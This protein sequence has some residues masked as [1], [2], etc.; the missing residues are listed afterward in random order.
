MELAGN[1][2]ARRTELGMTLDALAE[3]SRVSRAML[4]DIEREAKSPTL[5]IVAQIASGLG[6]TVSQLLGEPAPQAGQD[7][8]VLRKSQ[9]QIMVEPQSGVERHLLSP[10]L[11]RQG[12][13]VEWCVIPPGQSTGVYP[14]QPQGT[15]LNL[16]VVRGALKCKLGGNELLLE[17]GDS[18]TFAAD[19]EY[20]FA[21]AEKKPTRCVIVTDGGRKRI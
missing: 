13:E 1:I 17:E 3:K 6:C 7:V 20:S 18:V 8:Q 10:S 16:T 15:R 21:N 2:R 14:P 12:I 4:S 19:V 9:R 11:V 5:R